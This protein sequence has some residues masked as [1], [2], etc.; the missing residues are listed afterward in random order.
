MEILRIR[1]AE[2][3]L[4][5]Y[6]TTGPLGNQG[7]DHVAMVYSVANTEVRQMQFSDVEGISVPG[8][9]SFVMSFAQFGIS[10]HLPAV[11]HSTLCL[12]CPS[13][14]VLFFCS[15]IFGMMVGRVSL[16]VHAFL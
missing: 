2:R 4:G 7:G 6:G 16:A 10:R 13:S 15:T 14:R 1:Q 3:R 12:D 9:S 8:I 5:I 11:L